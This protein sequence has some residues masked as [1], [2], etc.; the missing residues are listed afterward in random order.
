MAAEILTREDLAIF[1]TELFRELRELV[2]APAIQ[3][4]KWLKSYEV[5]DLLGISPGTLQNMRINGT[6]S[7]T[8][9]GGLIFYE[10]DDILKLMEGTKKPVK[11]S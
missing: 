3:P 6:L 11:R 9:I 5:R 4:R 7:F 1:K 2:N 10:Y 8:K